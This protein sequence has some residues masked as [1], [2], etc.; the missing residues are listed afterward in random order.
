MGS[1]MPPALV[2]VVDRSGRLRGVRPL[3]PDDG[4]FPGE[5]TVDGAHLANITLTVVRMLWP[6]SIC[7]GELV[8]TIDEGVTAIHVHSGV[9]RAC[10]SVG[11]ARELVFTFDG[12]IDVSSMAI[13]LYQ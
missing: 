9:G 11:G 8:A 13:V 4:P 7:D 5:S 12:P 1:G 6:G 2:A 3:H 10:D